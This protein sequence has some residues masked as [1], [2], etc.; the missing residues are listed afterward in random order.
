VPGS[1]GA[2]AGP[3]PAAR[4]GARHPDPAVHRS[5]PLARP[6]DAGRWA[7]APGSPSPL[8]LL[9]SS[10][11]LNPGSGRRR[12]GTIGGSSPLLSSALLFGAA[13]S[14]PT[15]PS[16]FARGLVADRLAGSDPA[17]LGARGDRIVVIR[18]SRRSI[19]TRRDTFPSACAVARRVDPSCSC[20]FRF[21]SPRDARARSCARDLVL[22]SLE[23]SALLVC[24]NL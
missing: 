22:G 13:C 14:N 9:V 15:P 4:S 23:R 8:P 7:H 20:C 11:L 3:H 10:P 16:S 1:N 6:A 17:G 12:R 24:S 19:G 2:G 18:R 5:T 21:S